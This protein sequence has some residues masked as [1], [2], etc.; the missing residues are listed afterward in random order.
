MMWPRPPAIKRSKVKVVYDRPSKSLFGIPK[1]LLTLSA[2]RVCSGHAVHQ[3][4]KRRGAKL[5]RALIKDG[6]K[7]EYISIPS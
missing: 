3:F 7:Y 4:S 2:I 5:K 1:N 6:S